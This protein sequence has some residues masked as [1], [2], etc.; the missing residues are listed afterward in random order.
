MYI[1]VEHEPRTTKRQKPIMMNRT[2]I[3]SIAGFSSDVSCVVTSTW[4]ISVIFSEYI[5]CPVVPV[6]TNI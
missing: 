4:D 2:C 5:D 6:I 3:L 1:T